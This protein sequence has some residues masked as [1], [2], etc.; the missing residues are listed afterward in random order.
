MLYRCC[1]CENTFTEDEIEVKEY[2]IGEAWGQLQYEHYGVC[3]YCGG[4]DYE[5]VEVDND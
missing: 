4:A 1:K 5:E 2:C 3:P